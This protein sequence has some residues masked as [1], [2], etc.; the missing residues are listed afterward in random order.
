MTKFISTG[1]TGDPRKWHIFPYFS[2]NDPS[3]KRTRLTG[4]ALCGTRADCPSGDKGTGAL[5]GGSLDS[6]GE[7]V[8]WLAEFAYVHDPN[9]L[10]AQ[11]L[12]GDLKRANTPRRFCPHCAKIIAEGKAFDKRFLEQLRHA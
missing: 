4:P 11:R 8:D 1:F 10:L 12:N 7:G 9:S 3:R 6:T 2:V 5:V